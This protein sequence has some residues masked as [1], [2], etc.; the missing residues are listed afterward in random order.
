MCVRVCAVCTI[1]VSDVSRSCVSC[2]VCVPSICVVY[3]CMW[4]DEVVG[5]KVGNAIMVGWWE[6]EEKRR[7]KFGRLYLWFWCGLCGRWEME[8]CLKEVNWWLMK[9]LKLSKQ[10]WQF[11]CEEQL[12]RFSLLSAWFGVCLILS[13]SDTVW[14][15]SGFAESAG[16]LLVCWKGLRAAGALFTGCV[17]CTYALLLFVGSCCL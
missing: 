17:E 14:G 12:G 11:G 2:A 15:K 6:D 1:W 10:E 8:C 16:W 4:C 3:V 7:G 9:C 5:S 13:R